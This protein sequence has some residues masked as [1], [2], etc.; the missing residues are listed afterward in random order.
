M[1]IKRSKVLNK[2]SQITDEAS[3]N[4]VHS[5]RAPIFWPKALHGMFLDDATEHGDNDE[6]EE[7][8]SDLD[9]EEEFE[10]SNE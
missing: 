2:M 7:E 9:C 6:A 3:T 4:T 10:E 1:I 5:E 8:H